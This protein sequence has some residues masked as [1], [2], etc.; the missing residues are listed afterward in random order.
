MQRLLESAEANVFQEKELAEGLRRRMGRELLVTT[1]TFSPD[2]VTTGAFRMEEGLQRCKLR[3]SHV[4]R[5]IFSSSGLHSQ[6]ISL[7]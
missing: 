5:Y 2:S 6:V 3:R 4:E 7:I 1:R